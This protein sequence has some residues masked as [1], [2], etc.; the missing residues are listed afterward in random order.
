M[1]S[2]ACDQLSK[3]VRLR[4]L[5][6]IVLNIGN[7]LNTAGPTKKGKAGAFTLDSLLKLNQAKAFDKKTTFLHYVIVILKRN[8]EQLLSFKDDLPS[9]FKSEKIYWDQCLLDLEEAEDQVDNLRI[10]ALKKAREQRP[11]F[12]KNAKKFKNV[13]DD[14]SITDE[15]LC[16]E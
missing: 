1:I 12:V 9:V 7:R 6:G 10:G 16:L 11:E 14:G 13:R 8:N 2:Q 3:S 5:L 4:K 15:S